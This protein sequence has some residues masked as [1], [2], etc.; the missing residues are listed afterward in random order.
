MRKLTQLYSL[1]ICIAVIIFITNSHAR[2]TIT[3]KEENELRIH[4]LPVGAGTCT[5][6]ECPGKNANNMLIDCGS[7]GGTTRKFEPEE[8]IKYI[9]ENIP[10]FYEN[11]PDV[12]ISHADA[13]HYNYVDDVLNKTDVNSVWLGGQQRKY[14]ELDK[15]NNFKRWM[16]LQ[17]EKKKVVSKFPYH[18]HN[19]GK[20]LNSVSCGSADVFVLT[21]NSS[22]RFD[23]DKDCDD[24]EIK[25]G[26]SLVL[27]INYGNFTAVFPGDAEGSTELQAIKNYK[28]NNNTS[29]DV[30][31]LS[32]SH[33]G[34]STHG[35]NGMD[36]EDGDEYIIEPTPSKWH[37]ITKP[38]IVIYSAGT[39]YLHPR[40]KV[41]KQYEGSLKEANPHYI[42]CGD[43]E[44]KKYKS[45]YKTRKAEYVT[46][47][48]GAIIVTT[49][50]N[51]KA[52][53][54]CMGKYQCKDDVIFEPYR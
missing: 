51:N 10:S 38:E 44:E 31:L 12:M 18:W 11:P 28:T 46:G 48:N 53:V 50:G 37:D 7:T 52:N 30:D 5:L 29:L 9:S 15:K 25:N 14:D 27:S 6:V 19:G 36:Y 47:M 32:A 8:V 49:D 21:V 39:K 54:L 26:N 33:H 3:A 4:H 16:N 13:D 17:E 43:S 23:E 42:R 34:A 40:C 41:L 1:S 20:P 45:R 24:D 35:S 2:S 22:I